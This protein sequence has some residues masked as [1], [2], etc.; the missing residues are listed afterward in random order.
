MVNE[1]NVQK[2]LRQDVFG[3]INPKI[4]LVSNFDESGLRNFESDFSKAVNIGQ[5][6]I[7]IKVDSYGGEVYA[8]QGM[9]DL[10]ESSK[11]PVATIMTSKGMS[12]GS[13]LTAF[14]TLGYRYASPNATLMI[15]D[16]G[17]GAFDKYGEVI[18][19]AEELKRLND[20]LFK[21]M[22]RHCGYQDEGFFLKQIHERGH[23]DWYLDAK[24]MKRLN[25]IDHIGYP[26]MVTE[27][28]FVNKLEL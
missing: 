19:R 14:G 13:F 1:I 20:S 11:T 23:S 10:I 3:D 4:V 15:H 5:N 21:R 22:A 9:I 12:C 27:V 17:G 6:I 18:V 28:T 2:G 26:K 8:L 7:P 16:I 25:L 24:E